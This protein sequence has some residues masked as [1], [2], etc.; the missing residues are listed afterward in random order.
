MLGYDDLLGELV[1][2]LWYVSDDPDHAP[3][4]IPTFAR[5]VYDVT[6]AG[7]TVVAVFVSAVAAGADEVEA[8]I[9]A[10]AGAGYTVAQIGTASVTIEQLRKELELNL[11][12]GRLAAA[13]DGEPES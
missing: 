4:H 13:R 8:A 11:N 9:V 6:G 5:N 1:A 2:Q 10:N 3:T 12:T 7:D